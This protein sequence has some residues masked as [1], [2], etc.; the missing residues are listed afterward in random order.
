M[1]DWEEGDKVSICSEGGGME[2]IEHFE[3]EL[4]QKY[5]K[6]LQGAKVCKMWESKSSNVQMIIWQ[7]VDP[8]LDFKWEGGFNVFFMWE[9]S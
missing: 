1:E 7:G 8:G 3:E 4:M 9:V 6:S 5:H 2:K